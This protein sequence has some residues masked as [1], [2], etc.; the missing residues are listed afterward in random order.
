M[1]Q[2]TLALCGL[3]VLVFL[4]GCSFGGGE[5]PEDELTGEAEYDWDTNAS[6]SFTLHDS[7]RFSFSSETYAAVI[8]IDNQSSLGVYSETAL[9]G[10][11]SI[12]IEALQFQFTNG[13]VVNATHQNLTAIEGSGETEIRLPAANGTV[14]YTTARDG[15]R[16]STPVFVDSAHQVTLPAGGR[17]GIPLLSRTRPGG[18][19]TSVTDNR[20]TIQWEE[21]DRNQM[22]VRF[23][24][25]RDIYL[26]GGVVAIAGMVGAGGLL[27]YLRAIRAAKKKREDVGLDIEMEDDEFD[28][29][30]P[31]GMR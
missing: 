20:M 4:A 26:L 22:L 1:R 7:E 17:V 15:K 14:G 9:Q 31:P 8:R 6:A 2:R 28:D 16:W 19:E 21:V 27:Y 29:G 25:V 5:I 30:P 3:A 13:T 10:D 23:Y 24:L 18:Y 12:Q 11:S